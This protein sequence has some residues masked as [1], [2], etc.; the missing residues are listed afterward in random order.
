MKSSS[1]KNSAKFQPDD[2]QLR[3]YVS[4]AGL[5][6]AGVAGKF[7]L[8]FAGKV[9][10]DIGSSTGGF[11]DFALRSGAAKV[12]AV[13][14]GTNQLHVSLRGNPKVELYEKTDIRDVA[15]VSAPITVAVARATVKPKIIVQKPAVILIDVSFISIREI[16]LHVAQY[17][18]TPDTEIVA[19]VKP[20]FEAGAKLKNAG[21]IKNDTV[22]RQILKDFEFWAKKHF[23]IRQ[24]VD[25]PVAGAHG[26]RERFYLLMKAKR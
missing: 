13:D 5:K 16:L 8:D 18:A 7:G 19:M 11:T 22:R 15:A 1:G 9:V 25:S 2:N 26:N 24:K 3:T 4:R 6:L 23:V 20:Q 10:L 12:I 17:F 14:V 21:V